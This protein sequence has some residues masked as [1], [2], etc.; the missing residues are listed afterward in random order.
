V[1]GGELLDKG[2][3]LSNPSLVKVWELS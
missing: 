1:K 2:V 3:K